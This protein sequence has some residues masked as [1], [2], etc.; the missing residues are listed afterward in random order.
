MKEMTLQNVKEQQ[1]FEDFC[2]KQ[3][4]QRL[5]LS[6][7]SICSQSEGVRSFVVGEMPGG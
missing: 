5:G 3:M 7:M 2:G 1:S 6:H 4:T